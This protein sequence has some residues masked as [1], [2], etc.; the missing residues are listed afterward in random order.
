MTAILFRHDTSETM[1]GVFLAAAA[2]AFSSGGDVI[3]KMLSAGHP[4]FQLLAINSLFA[5]IPVFFCV[6][7]SGGLR[8]V[9][10][11][12]PGRHLIRAGLGVISTLVGV[13]AF[14]SL[15]LTDF[16]AI[17]FAG[18]L[19]VT[20]LS[21]K[22]LG[23]KVDRAGWMAIGGGFAGVLI[24]IAPAFLAGGAQGVSTV[25]TMIGRGAALLCVLF[26]AL[27]V[28][29]VRRMKGQETS[30]VFSVFGY[31]VSMSASLVL[32]LLFGAPPLSMAEIHMLMLAGLVNSIGNL[33]LME[34]YCRA[35]VALV[36]PFQYTQI[37]W[38]AI[39][40]FAL[41]HAVPQ[42]S[43]V[44]G[45]CVVMASGFYLLHRG[46]KRPKAVSGV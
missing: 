26:Y 13:Y 38:G 1:S 40:G 4:C 16:Y 27:S 6:W 32:W 20:A 28:L 42:P 44:A 46:Q 15:P 37:V 43:L 31:G 23:E 36:A 11:A 34:A 3:Y 8:L 10:T 29:M 5:L 41:W 25:E 9:R 14:K 2:F 22:F 45:A 19:L 21:S 35:P 17:I 33:C 12:R 18:P 7:W 30:L 39:A 24:V